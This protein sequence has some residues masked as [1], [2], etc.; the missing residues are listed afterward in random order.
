MI[1]VGVVSG[2]TCGLYDGTFFSQRLGTLL[3]N[4]K[5]QL[6]QLSEE[7][8]Q[9]IRKE[10]VDMMLGKM[11]DMK[12]PIG[13]EEDLEA[14]VKLD[15]KNIRHL[16]LLDASVTKADF[17]AKMIKE[18]PSVLSF[19]TVEQ[20]SEI[21]NGDPSYVAQLVKSNVELAKQSP[22]LEIIESNP[23]LKKEIT[24]LEMESK[25][26]KLEQEVD[27]QEQELAQLR[28]PEQQLQE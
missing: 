24:I 13:D 10:A 20:I 9:D 25:V 26:E 4:F 21:S 16:N 6:E 15:P 11:S 18:N 27:A 7:E 2:E 22:I 1:E 3:K 8:R 14:Y 19:M 17:L 28:E 5:Q 12:V 23:E